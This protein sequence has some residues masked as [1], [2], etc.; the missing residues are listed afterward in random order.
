M[1]IKLLIHSVIKLSFCL[2]LSSGV[3]FAS[4]L[5]VRIDDPVYDYLDRLS[6]QGVL[7]SYMNATLPLNRDY[8]ADMLAHLA[9]K[10]DLLSVIV[11][12]FLDEY[13]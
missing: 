2:I 11:S 7:P 9:T 1:K 4:Q 3:Y 10:R 12:K 13:I 5:H 8:I 6:T